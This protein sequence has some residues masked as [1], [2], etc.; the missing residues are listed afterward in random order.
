[1]PYFDDGK[2]RKRPLKAPRNGLGLRLLDV[3]DP[4]RVRH[5]KSVFEIHTHDQAAPESAGFVHVRAKL[6][7][8]ERGR[9]GSGM[10]SAQL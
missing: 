5:F 1:M 9:L 3:I 6:Q 8:K 10:S 2:T 7:Q 4:D